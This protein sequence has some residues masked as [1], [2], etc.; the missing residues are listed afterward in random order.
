MNKLLLTMLFFSSLCCAEN[1]IYLVRHA[2][3]ITTKDVKD[4]ELTAIGEFRALNIAK[5]LSEVGITKIFST[6][7]KRTIQTAQP[8]ADYLGLEIEHYDPRH[9]SEFA[10]KIKNMQGNF[11]IVGHS[12]TTP[13]LTQLI[14]S[15]EVNPIHEGEYDNLYQVII[16]E[17]QTLLNRFKSIPSYDVKSTKSQSQKKLKTNK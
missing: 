7:Y 11:L 17:N 8:L 4:P 14:S 1:T 10:D 12:N 15:K 2:E 3:K 5:Q 16:S 9:L 13:Q 6:K